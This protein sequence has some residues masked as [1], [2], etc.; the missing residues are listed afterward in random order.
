MQLITHYNS[1][2]KKLQTLFRNLNLNYI[3]KNLI[4]EYPS[5]LSSSSG[6]NL[7]PL[8]MFAS[9]SSLIF[10]YFQFRALTLPSPLLSWVKCS[11]LAT[12]PCKFRPYLKFTK[13]KSRWK[14]VAPKSLQKGRGRGCHKTNQTKVPCAR[15]KC[16]LV[17]T[18]RTS[19]CLKTR[20]KK[21]SPTKSF[22]SHICLPTSRNRMVSAG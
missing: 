13:T 1:P 20:V 14:S 4:D 15:K 3:K 16:A 17:L 10:V 6:N 5:V 19:R 11:F 18:E 22:C 12:L 8:L 21:L 7:E 2:V 9:M